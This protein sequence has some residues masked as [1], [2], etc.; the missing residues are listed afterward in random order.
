[1]HC[2]GSAP[3]ARLRSALTHSA[4]LQASFWLVASFVG[5]ALGYL[6]M[7]HSVLATDPAVLA[8]ILVVFGMLVG[9]AMPTPLRMTITL[10]LMTLSAVMVCQCCSVGSLA[11]PVA[12]VASVLAGIGLAIVVNSLWWPWYTSD[13]SIELLALALKRGTVALLAM[14]A[15]YYADT[16]AATASYESATPANPAAAAFLGSGCGTSI[17][18]PPADVAAAA[19]LAA[20]VAAAAAAA[21]KQLGCTPP[22]APPAPA[23]GKQAGLPVAA[24]AGAP[25]PGGAAAAG[26]RVTPPMLQ[27][28]I[29]MPLVQVQAALIKDTVTWQR[30]VLATP[31]VRGWSGLP[32]C[33]CACRAVSMRATGVLLNAHLTHPHTP[34]HAAAGGAAHAAGAARPAGPAGGAAA[35]TAAAWHLWRVHGRVHGALPGAH[36]RPHAG[37]VRPADAAG[38]RDSTGAGAAVP[39]ARRGGAGPGACWGAAR[40]CVVCVL[41][42]PGIPAVAHS[43]VR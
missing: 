32:T 3:L 38:G 33:A 40:L 21:A 23:P 31:P 9:L 27:Q 7:L 16:A 6:A 42:A 20:A 17:K 10:S 34:R 12:R 29:G 22:P 41:L 39:Q 5:G 13:A 8:A 4:A 43:L 19:E 35:D 24:P 26:A 30:G 14:T 37:V 1:M 18:Q 15:Q 11:V 36:A 28:Q 2:L 25:A